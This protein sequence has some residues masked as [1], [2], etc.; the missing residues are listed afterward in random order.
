MERPF[1]L[2]IKGEWVSGI[3]DRVVLERDKKGAWTSAVILDFKTDDVSDP[4]TLQERARGYAPQLAL[5]AQA[6][7][8]LTHLP[9]DS[10]R[11]ALIF[12]SVARIHWMEP[13]EN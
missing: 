10:I 5:Y 7:S 12:T 9:P 8:R 6:V 13:G 1:D 2:S 3:I 4:A 11:T